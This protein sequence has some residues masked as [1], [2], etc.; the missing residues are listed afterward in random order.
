MTPPKLPYSK[1]VEG[2]RNRKVF[3]MTYQEHARQREASAM[4]HRLRLR[5]INHCIKPLEVIWCCAHCHRQ[6]HK[7]N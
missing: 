4:G 2:K 5:A 1:A 6:F 3:D 7:E